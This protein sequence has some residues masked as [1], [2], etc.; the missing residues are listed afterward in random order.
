MTLAYAYLVLTGFV[1]FLVLSNVHGAYRDR[2]YMPGM[3]SPQGKMNSQGGAELVPVKQPLPSPDLEMTFCQAAKFFA[4][5]IDEERKSIHDLYE[6]RRKLENDTIKNRKH[7]GMH[8]LKGSESVIHWFQSGSVITAALY[9][10]IGLNGALI[11]GVVY[12]HPRLTLCV[13]VLLLCITVPAYQHVTSKYE[14][15]KI[16]SEDWL[17]WSNWCV[18]SCELE[19]HSESEC[20]ENCNTLQ[21]E[22][23]EHKALWQPV[24]AS[25]GLLDDYYDRWHKQQ[26]E[27]TS[28]IITQ[29]E[30]KHLK[31][32]D[33]TQKK[34]REER[35]KE[36]ARTLAR[37]ETR[38]QKALSYCELMPDNIIGQHP[39]VLP[40]FIDAQ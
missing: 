28:A 21:A 40:Y 7:A 17:T 14:Q 29:V 15:A 27:F 2:S 30:A 35:E 6:H 32:I 34:W 8:F 10:F 18:E 25:Y 16:S 36:Q 1:M 33:D 38:R 12:H 26:R 22:L 4:Q 31:N 23:A 9:W 13:S 3:R 37:L 5:Q 20:E 39:N 19:G 24:Y 11:V